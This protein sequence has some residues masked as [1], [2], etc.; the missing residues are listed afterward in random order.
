M[1]LSD[2]SHMPNPSYYY[3][4]DVREAVKKLEKEFE[5]LCDRWEFHTALS[6]NLVGEMSDKIDEI[7]GEK[8]TSP[9]IKS[10][11]EKEE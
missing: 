1:S 5:D 3:E 4:E 6:V 9:K 10:S 2:K 7:F 11:E 8:L